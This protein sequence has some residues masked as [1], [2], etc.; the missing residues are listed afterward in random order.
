MGTKGTVIQDIE[1]IQLMLY[2]HV[3]GMNHGRLPRMA[4]E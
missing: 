2:D 4:M 3:N 1:E